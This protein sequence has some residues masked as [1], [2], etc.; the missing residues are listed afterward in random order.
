[1]ATVARTPKGLLPSVKHGKMV[2]DGNEDNG[3]LINKNQ[4]VPE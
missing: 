2:K 4:S 3:S 1:M